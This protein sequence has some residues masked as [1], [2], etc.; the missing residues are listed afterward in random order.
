MESIISHLI[1]DPTWVKM[2]AI[3]SA[4]LFGIL[5]LFTVIEANNDDKEG[6]TKGLKIT[7]KYLFLCSG[8]FVF[9]IT[10]IGLIFQKPNAYQKIIKNKEYTLTKNNKILT[11]SSKNEF[12]PSTN[13]EIIYDDDK[14][15]QVKLDNN[16]YTIDKSTETIN[17][18]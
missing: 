9:L 2:T 8:I 17:G 7:I 1:V 11:I 15:I 18:D 4:I 16:L 13:L 3:G 14:T 6:K 5:A 12:L 10:P